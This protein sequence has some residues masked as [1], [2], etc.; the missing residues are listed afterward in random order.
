M[1]LHETVRTI[2]TVCAACP[3]P[4]YDFMSMVKAFGAG[5]LTFPIVYYVIR[6]F[7]KQ[8][9]ADVKTLWAKLFTKAQAE[10]TIIEAHN[11]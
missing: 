6:I 4:P 7:G 9:T 5:F 3:I 10:V 2:H 1:A 11:A 8:I